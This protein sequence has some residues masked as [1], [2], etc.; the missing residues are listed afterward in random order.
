M[1]EQNGIPAGPIVEALIPIVAGQIQQAR[2]VTLEVAMKYATDAIKYYGKGEPFCC[3]LG[4]EKLKAIITKV[5]TN[6]EIKKAA[7]KA[8]EQVK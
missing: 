2:G 3:K 7:K 1:L 5:A 8:A 6:Y 4:D